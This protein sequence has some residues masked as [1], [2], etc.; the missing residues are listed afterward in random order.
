M[1][2][3]SAQTLRNSGNRYSPPSRVRPCGMSE[4]GVGRECQNAN[5]F[6]GSCNSAQL[7]SQL[8]EQ[9]SDAARRASRPPATAQSECLINDSPARRRDAAAKGGLSRAARSVI[10]MNE[11]V[12]A[13]GG[14][15]RDGGRRVGARA[16]HFQTDDDGR[17]VFPSALCSCTNWR[18]QMGGRGRGRSRRT[19]RN[20]GGSNYAPR[21]KQLARSFFGDAYGRTNARTHGVT[22]GRS[23]TDGRMNLPPSLRLLLMP[24]DAPPAPFTQLD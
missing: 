8:A 16:V 2:L 22:D 7:G 21:G 20:E 14:S 17:I 11:R 12:E 5:M 15:R 4:S 24:R 3:D 13:K 23:G 9:K 1:S 18:I 6:K 19:D 10:R